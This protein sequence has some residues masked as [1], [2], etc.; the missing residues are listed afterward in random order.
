MIKIGRSIWIWQL[1]TGRNERKKRKERKS[2]ISN[3][4]QELK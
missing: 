2:S 4:D 3:S 1:I